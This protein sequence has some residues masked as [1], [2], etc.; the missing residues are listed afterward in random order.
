M[1]DGVVIVHLPE[2]K[3]DLIYSQHLSCPKCDINL[4][5]IEPRNFSFNSPHGACPEC[6]GLGTKLEI[7]PNLVIPN[8]KLSLAEG[9]IRPW[10]R[11]ASNQTWYYRMLENVAK[12]YKFSTRAPA[13][14]FRA[15]VSPHVS[16]YLASDIF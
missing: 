6:S 3:K 16:L 9:A 7:D 10:S 15:L 13:V 4:P 5:K 2:N 12:A 11:T 1:G 14:A 8:K